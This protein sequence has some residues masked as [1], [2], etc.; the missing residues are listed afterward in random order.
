MKDKFPGYYYRP[1]PADLRRLWSRAD[2]VPD[3]NVLLDLYRYSPSRRDEWLALLDR[4]SSRLWLPHQVALEYHRN[5]ADCMARVIGDLDAASGEL[6]NW[7]KGL[8]RCVG[9]LSKR[10]FLDIPSSL[11]AI[12]GLVEPIRKAI[13][14]RRRELR[15]LLSNDRVLDRITAIFGGRVGEPYDAEAME[16][17]CAEGRR[18]FERRIPP[19]FEDREKAA[20]DVYGDWIL[21]SQVLDHAKEAGKPILFVTADMKPDWWSIVRGRSKPRPRPELVQEM[22][23]RSGERFHAYQT[24]DFLEAAKQYLNTKVSEE[25]VREAREVKHQ[26]D[27]W[28]NSP[29]QL[30]SLGATL[31]EMERLRALR[32]FLPPGTAKA[33]AEMDRIRRDV[34]K[35][36]SIIKNALTPSGL[37]R[38]YQALFDSYRWLTKGSARPG[39]QRKSPSE[40]AEEESDELGPADADSDT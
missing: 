9:G 12:Q 13:A 18:R 24:D 16:S 21:W 3:A 35:W 17:L 36:G 37:P 31:A 5:R 15:E 23:A 11:D 39:D 20:G 4:M 28:T 1:T 10:K 7:C 38:P 29:A 8:K 2:I 40:Q 6:A 22:H 26:R 14:D 33:I 27:V 34:E 32:E 30:R 19:G 25:A